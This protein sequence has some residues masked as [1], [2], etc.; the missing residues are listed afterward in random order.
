MSKKRMK[1]KNLF[2]ATFITIIIII[3][4]FVFV[5]NTTLSLGPN[6][7]R[8]VRSAC[9][10]H[11][12]NDGDGF[13]DFSWRKAY[14]SDGSILG[15]LD[16]ISKSDNDEGEAC[17][18]QCSTD[19]D[20]GINGFIGSKYCGTDGNVYQ[21]YKT[22][23]CQNPGTCNAVCSNQVTSTLIEACSN[24]CTNGQCN[25]INN[26]MQ[27]VKVA[28]IGDQDVNVNARAVLQLIK[29]EGA[30]FV[31]H[32]GDLG[33]G[34]ETSLQRVN[35]WDKQINDILGANYPYF[36]SVGNHDVNSW[37]AYQQK[38]IERLERISD[39]NCIGNIG[40][41]SSCYYRGIFFILSGA[42]TLESGHTE[43][44]TQQLEQNNA[45][46]RICSWHKNQQ[47]MQIGGKT[48]EVGWGPYETCRQKGAII[49]TAHEHSYER[50]KTLVNTQTQTVDLS[51]PDS[52]NVR[53]A[54]GATFVFVSGLGGQSIRNQ[55]RCLPTT[56]PYGCNGEWA[57]IYTSDQGAS[58]GALF[59]TFRV[60]NQENKAFCYFKDI[61]G[62]VPDQF[63]ITSE[64]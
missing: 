56:Y 21:D 53:V 18:P 14:C 28:F 39:E 50:T 3:V 5:L 36:Y 4:L 26:S 1:G 38:L 59:C 47:Q 2:I 54:R 40:V 61:N 41:K 22:F 25:V 11:A 35:D 42:G 7:A 27:S 57:S 24:G 43:Y 12:D 44:I 23:I 64:L 8:V 60:N 6:K 48:D 31:L 55:Q 19:A 29:N 52:D 16:C 33:Y 51:W 10:D 63:N 37:S 45:T 34:D 30:D 49:A 46:W 13:C 17:I 20:C 62:R 9:S 58:Y 32:Q 15:D